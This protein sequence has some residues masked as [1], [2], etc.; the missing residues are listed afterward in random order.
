[1]PLNPYYLKE[2]IWRDY[3]MMVLDLHPEVEQENF[4]EKKF[5]KVAFL[6]S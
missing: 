1:M 5:D 3:Y 6:N 2:L 4:K